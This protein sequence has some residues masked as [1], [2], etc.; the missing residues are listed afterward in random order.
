M[1][2]LWRRT[3]WCSL[4]LALGLATAQLTAAET[5]LVYSPIAPQK[6]AADTVLRTIYFPQITQRKFEA[7]TSKGYVWRKLNQEHFLYFRNEKLEVT[8]DVLFSGNPYFFS[9]NSDAFKAERSDVFNYRNTRGFMACG[10]YGDRLTF[11]TAYAETQAFFPEYFTQIVFDN[12]EWYYANG[13]YRQDDNKGMIPGQGRA[14][15]FKDVGYDW[16]W[17]FSSVNWKVN[18]WLNINIGNDKQF[19]GSGY[20]SLLLSDNAFNAPGL[21]AVFKLGAFTYVQQ[22][23]LLQSLHRV[24]V[25]NPLR[26]ERF[27]RK[28]LNHHYLAWNYNNRVEVGLFEATVWQLEDSTG[29]RSPAAGLYNPI[30][31]GDALLGSS[32]NGNNKHLL[33]FQLT[34]MIKKPLKAYAQYLTAG[35]ESWGFQMGSRYTN[36]WGKIRLDALIEYNSAARNTYL[37]DN[38]LQAYTHYTQPLA[39]PFVDGF[40]EIVMKANVGYGRWYIELSNIYAGRREVG[41]FVFSQASFHYTMNPSTRM[42]L[43]LCWQQ[44]DAQNATNSEQILS[45]GWRT[46]LW[47]EYHDL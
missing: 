19:V 34:A 26:E 32:W 16:G 29:R 40:S 33:G 14:K 18:S 44:R 6:V 43:Y 22:W 13:T 24:P 30:I 23:S 15:L 25:H 42:E 38:P 17:A 21:R 5:N 45:L 11:Y 3:F 8:G 9:G 47:E 4:C 20:R 28:A 12:R 31:L 36:A 37:N 46:R 10:Q 1:Q 39:H 35:P 2:T 7:D 41:Y 27:M